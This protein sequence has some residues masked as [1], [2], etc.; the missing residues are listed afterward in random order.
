VS[1]RPG[2]AERDPPGLSPFELERP[3][4]MESSLCTPHPYVG[5]FMTNGPDRAWWGGAGWR[6]GHFAWSVSCQWSRP[7]D[8]WAGQR[9]A[10]QPWR[11]SPTASAA[12]KSQVRAAGPRSWGA[13]QLLA[14][15]LSGQ[16]TNCRWS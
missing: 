8:D 7:G 15:E 13:V 2:G 16:R 9:P 1:H 3:T 10:T 4:L 6:H 12:C 14:R 11:S 5:A